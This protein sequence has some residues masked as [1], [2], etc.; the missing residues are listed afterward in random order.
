[1]GFIVMAM[2]IVGIYVNR[3]I[4]APRSYVTVT[5]KG[6]RPSLTTLGRWRYAALAFNLLYI[7]L[8]IVLPLGVLLIVSFSWVWSGEID[9]S[10]LTL[11]N[12]QKMFQ[13]PET[14]R[15]IRNSLF[16]AVTAASAGTLL[17][18]V[19]SYIIHRTRYRG[20]ALLDFVATIPIAVPGV[21]LGVALL[22]VWIATP[23]YQT[24]GIL[25]LAYV[26]RWLPVCQKN[27]A[28]VLM[29][30]SPELDESAR[31]S[32]GSWLFVMRRI[33]LPLLKPGL[34]ASWLMLFVIS[35]R[36]MSASL[37]L[38]TTGTETMSV[39]LWLMIRKDMPTVAA[40]AMVQTLIL[41]VSSWLF[42]RVAGREMTV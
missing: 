17:A 42:T 26:T 8:T 34:V 22:S 10:Q 7:L 31:V 33:M 16:L 36:E 1:V 30:V 37:L 2:T 20:R 25:F 29:A 15:G 18:A 41:L 4:I 19:L 6:W 32:G 3:R 23:L 39:A 27:I 5:G 24:L 13:T 21:A 28:S 14:S 11:K 35:I 12:Y 38:Y 40:F 9:F